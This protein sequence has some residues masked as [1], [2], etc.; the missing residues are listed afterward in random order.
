MIGKSYVPDFFEFCRQGHCGRER[1]IQGKMWRHL[2]TLM[3]DSIPKSNLQE[4]MQFFLE[5]QRLFRA[6]QY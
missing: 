2:Q 6:I 4:K 3:Q 5:E 1:R